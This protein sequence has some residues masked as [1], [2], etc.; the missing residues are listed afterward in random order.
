MKNWRVALI[1]LFS[2]LMAVFARA[3][4]NHDKARQLKDMG[5]IL[6]LEQILQV[7]RREH[8]GRVI[9]VELEKE[10]GRYVYEVE[11]LDKRGEVWELYFDAASAELIKRKREN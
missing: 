4:V 6:P 1:V 5:E 7:A 2:L 11:I 9:E 10:D 3:D 8:P